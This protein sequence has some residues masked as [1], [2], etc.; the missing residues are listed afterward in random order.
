M[1]PF[2]VILSLTLVGV[3]IGIMSDRFAFNEAG[4]GK[5]II[6]FWTLYNLVTLVVT[7]LVCIELPRVEHHFGDRPERTLI[8]VGGK[9]TRVWLTDITQET[10]RIRGVDLSPGTEIVINIRKIGEVQAYVL[11]KT[12]DGARLSLELDPQQYD[13][14][15]RRLYSE[16]DVPSVT[17]TRVGALARDAIGR[18]MS[19]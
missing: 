5:A 14:L 13:A 3:V 12:S 1:R 11:E 2:L 10:A 7:L 19:T 15:L 6:L 9:L 8:S 16:G 18:L 17:K 4:E